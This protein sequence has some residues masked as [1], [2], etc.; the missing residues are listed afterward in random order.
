MLPSQDL[1]SH[2]Q[3]VCMIAGKKFNFDRRRD[4]ITAHRQTRFRFRMT[5][6][7]HFLSPFLI[8]QVATRKMPR[9]RWR[10][11][12]VQRKRPEQSLLN[13]E[14]GLRRPRTFSLPLVRERERIWGYS[15]KSKVLRFGTKLPIIGSQPKYW[16]D[17]GHVGC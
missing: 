3:D 6:H 5:S 15:P 4:S 10:V 2:V 7:Y 13:V 14:T 8:Q 16:A 11:K 1:V 17:S 9:E 12:I